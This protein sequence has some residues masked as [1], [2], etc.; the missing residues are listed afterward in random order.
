MPVKKYA[1]QVCSCGK[2]VWWKN[3]SRY[4]NL[5]YEADSFGGKS[6]RQHFC[7]SKSAYASTIEDGNRGLLRACPWLQREGEV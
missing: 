3:T 7:A 1:A 4:G 2:T 5:P 6:M